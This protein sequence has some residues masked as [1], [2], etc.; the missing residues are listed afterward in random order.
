[1]EPTF[2]LGS[3][4]HLEQAII[5][6]LLTGLAFLK[7]LLPLQLYWVGLARV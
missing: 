3:W 2:L 5:K 6:L 4:F 7:L 1:M